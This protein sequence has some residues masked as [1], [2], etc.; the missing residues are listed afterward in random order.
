MKKFIPLI[1][2]CTAMITCVIKPECQR[3]WNNK[4]KQYNI[5]FTECITGNSNNIVL[6]NNFKKLAYG[7]S[8]LNLNRH[9]Y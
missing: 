6:R 4:F 7:Y 2:R 1:L 8:F 9:E 5:W 3:N